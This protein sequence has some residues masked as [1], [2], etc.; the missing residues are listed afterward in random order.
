MAL[1]MIPQAL[2]YVVIAGLDAKFGLYSSFLGLAVM[3]LL[4]TSRETVIGPSPISCPLMKDFIRIPTEWPFNPAW[5]G[6][7][8]SPYLSQMLTFWTG[9]IMAVLG[10]IRGGFILNFVSNAVVAGFLQAQ[11]MNHMTTLVFE[12]NL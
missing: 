11:E 8:S 10:L 4:T 9:L 5:R 7:F 2:A 6:G 1:L 3:A 12:V